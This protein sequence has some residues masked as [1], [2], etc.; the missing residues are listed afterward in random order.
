MEAAAVDL[1]MSVGQIAWINILLS[2]DNA[3]VIALACRSL[4]GMQRRLGIAL[5]AAAAVLLR[6]ALTAGAARILEVPYLAAVGGV[7]L[8]WIAVKLVVPGKEDSDNVKGH[9]TLWRAVVTVV[10]ADVIM[11]LDNVLAIA[12]AAHRR[13]ML[14]VFGL[15]LSIP[16]VIIGS[17]L[18]TAIVSRMP[19]LVWAGAALLGW[20][21]GDMIAS[22]E[23]AL[24]YIDANFPR[25]V[26]AAAGA[27][28]VVA[29][30]LLMTRL[31]RPPTP[32]TRDPAQR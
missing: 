26:F 1:G 8:I 4:V 15:V 16:I 28:L 5:G 7:A 25:Y 18:I 2:G 30:G 3:V 6:I 12:A 14:M 13:P 17:S 19:I 20:I 11:S 27:L 32:I 24:A 29:L 31:S 10:I 22:D 9:E 21:A 23:A